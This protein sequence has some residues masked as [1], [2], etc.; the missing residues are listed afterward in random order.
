MNR[1]DLY[2]EYLSGS[3]NE[4]GTAEFDKMQEIFEDSMQ[5][6]LN[7]LQ[8]TIEGIFTNAMNTDQFYDMIDATTKLVEVFDDLVQ[9]IGGGE[10]AM[11][12][13]LAVA[14][15]MFSGQIGQG[16]TNFISNRQQ[17]QKYKDNKAAAQAYAQEQ[18]AG[19]GLT[20]ADERTTRAANDIAGMDQYRT[21]FNLETEEKVNALAK[22]RLDLEVQFE[23]ALQKNEGM[24]SAIRLVAEDY[25]MTEKE[26]LE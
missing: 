25:N 15:K 7:K 11:T 13:F 2:K 16:I 4:T 18:L 9:S 23:A 1:S 8:A 14:T 22:E 10:Q 3:E 17:A 20:V 24:F 12:A 6:R 5:G 21:I 26:A 19:R